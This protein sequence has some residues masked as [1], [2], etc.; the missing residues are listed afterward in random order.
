MAVRTLFPLP[1]VEALE[2]YAKACQKYGYACAVHNF[3]QRPV[4]EYQVPCTYVEQQEVERL[5]AAMVSSRKELERAV[6]AHASQLYE[7]G[8]ELGRQGAV[9]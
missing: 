1:L 9:Q 4:D 8:L 6:E 5:H 2:E 3:S 7:G